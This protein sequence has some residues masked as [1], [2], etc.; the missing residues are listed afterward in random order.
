MARLTNLKINTNKKGSYI[1]EATISLPIFMIACIVLSSIVLM[2]SCVEDG[3]FIIANELRKSAAEAMYANTSALIPAR[4]STQLRKHSQV[5]STGIKDFAYR[6]SNSINDELIYLSIRMNMTA[7]N[8]LNLASEASYDVSLVTRAYVG[9][10]RNTG[11]MSEAEMMSAE[12]DSVYIFPKR[13][14]KYHSSGCTFLRAASRSSA[15]TSGIKDKYS[16]CPICHSSK[17]GEGALIYYFPSDGE[18]YHL[19]G[20]STL[21]RNYIEIE[22]NVALERGYTACSKCG[23]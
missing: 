21:Q 17:A 5:Q 7:E 18:S 12:S 6:S 20:C 13:G 14:E 11:N 22:K 9:K 2:F 8:P 4:V 1:L 10:K 16:P 3:N 15:L 23:G 19:P